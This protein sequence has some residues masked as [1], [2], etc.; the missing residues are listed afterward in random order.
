MFTLIFL[1]FLLA[2]LHTNDTNKT[3]TPI[4]LSICWQ[5]RAVCWP[6]L[7]RTA[8]WHVS[9]KTDNVVAQRVVELLTF[10][11]IMGIETVI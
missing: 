6:L 9:G 10:S 5:R 7:H 8:Y 2:S 1:M 11:S 3:P 4:D